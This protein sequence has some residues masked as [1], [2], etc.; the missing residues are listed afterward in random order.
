MFQEGV[1]CDRDRMGYARASL[2]KER[3]APLSRKKPRSQWSADLQRNSVQSDRRAAADL[4][5]ADCISKRRAGTDQELIGRNGR[6][7]EWSPFLP[8]LCA[9]DRFPP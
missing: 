9:P 8:I 2:R 7:R 5:S 4:I 1:V 3:P 6:V